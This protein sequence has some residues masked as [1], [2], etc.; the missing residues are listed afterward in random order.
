MA[1]DRTKDPA[2][3]RNA[4]AAGPARDWYTL[5]NADIGAKELPT[6]GRSL[7]VTVGSA[8]TVPV[9]VVVVPIGNT[10]DN[11]TRSLSI[12]TTGPL[13]LGVRRIVSINGGTT[14]PTGFQI[15]VV[16]K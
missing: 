4:D 3:A 14:I 5:A 2:G 13:P 12:S 11:A 8:V 10:D 16:T 1:Y 9:V 6:Y 7:Y 15:D